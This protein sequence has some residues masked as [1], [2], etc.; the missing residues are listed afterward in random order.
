VDS[1]DSGREV[2]AGSCEQGNEPSDSVQGGEFLNSW[3]YSPQGLD[4][5]G[6]LCI[7]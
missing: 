7:S 1:C 3:V 6:A 2:V 5:C 4:W